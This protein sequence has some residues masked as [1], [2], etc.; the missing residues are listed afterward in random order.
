LNLRYSFAPVT[1]PLALPISPFTTP[2]GQ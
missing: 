1:Q 2:F